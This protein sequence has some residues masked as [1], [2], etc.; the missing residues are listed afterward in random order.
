[1]KIKYL[2]LCDNNY[3]YEYDDSYWYEYDNNYW[4][5]YYDNYWYELNWISSSQVAELIALIQKEEE[6]ESK[7]AD[8]S[9]G[10]I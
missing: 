1:M 7:N 6:A 10:D 8:A 3:W 5:E 4:Y 9:T 2:N